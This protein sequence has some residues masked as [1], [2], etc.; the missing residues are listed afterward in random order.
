VGTGAVTHARHSWTN[1]GRTE[2]CCATRVST[3]EYTGQL[4]SLDLPQHGGRARH[5]IKPMKIVPTRARGNVCSTLAAPNSSARIS[6]N[7]LRKPTLVLYENDSNTLERNVRDHADDSAA[8]RCRRAQV[9]AIRRISMRRPQVQCADCSA[10][11]R[12]DAGAGPT[13]CACAHPLMEQASRP[14]SRARFPEP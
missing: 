7:L 3:I 2:P 8:Y 5:G 14:T 4:T 1:C 12:P 11:S 10:G 9:N 6:P 13:I